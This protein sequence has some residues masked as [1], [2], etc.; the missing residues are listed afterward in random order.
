MVLPQ[1][2]AERSL[3]L[4]HRALHRAGYL[5]S[6]SFEHYAAVW[7]RDAAMACLGCSRSGDPELVEGVETTLRTLAGKATPLGQLPAAYWPERAYWD[8]GESGTTDATAWFVIALAEHVDATD[9]ETVAGELWP[10]VERAMSWLAH[11][12]V[13]GTGLVDSPTG[14]SWMDSTL[15]PSGRVFHVNVLYHWAAAGATRLADRLGIESPV[16]ATLIAAAIDGL[17]WPAPGGDM[18]ELN[19]VRYPHQVVLEMPHP[20]AASEYVRLASADRRHYLASVAYGRFVDRCDVL[21]HC[22]GIVSGLIDATRSSSVLGYLADS[23]CAEPYPSRT[24]PTPFLPGEPGGL[25]DTDADVLQDPRW[26]NPPGSYHNGAVWPYIGAVHALA[27]AVAGQGERAAEL[28]AGTA[29]ANRL[30][31]W[32]FH[33]WITVPAGEPQGA[34]DQTWNAGAYLWAYSLIGG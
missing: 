1:E 25:L 8:W 10:Y 32:G 9:R 30:G 17:F 29:E 2:C 5:A 27:A 21:A 18:A 14:A 3:E 11:Q 23:D 31:D 20:L 4:L 19:I 22:L 6:P 28:L 33:E 24:W 12:D 7:T 16:D 34:R 13:T 15:S 26:R